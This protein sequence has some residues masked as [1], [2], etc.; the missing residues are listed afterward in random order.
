MAADRA[1][2]SNSKG[3]AKHMMIV[4]FAR[5]FN[6][7]LGEWLASLILVSMAI[8][9]FAET[10]LFAQSPMYFA[11]MGSVATQVQWGFLFGTFGWSR[12][13]A[14]WINGRK[15][16]TPYIRMGLS[17]LSCFVWFQVALSLFASGVPGLGWAIFPWL[18]ALEMYNVFRSS[19]DAREVFDHNRASQAYGTQNIS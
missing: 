1:T 14:L 17:F 2:P 3:S 15:P 6:I 19:A 18:L 10:K 8:L 16:I 9:F 7:R 13:A 11:V 4:S 12:I 5:H